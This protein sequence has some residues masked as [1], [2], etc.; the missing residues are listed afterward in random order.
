M[1]KAR[2]FILLTLVTLILF[3]SAIKPTQRVKAGFIVEYYTVWYDCIVGPPALTPVGEWRRDCF[4]MTGW[5]WEPGHS[6]TYTITNWG[7]EC[8]VE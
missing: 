3:G 8:T 1:R 5:G 6:C 7:E 2:F 4:G